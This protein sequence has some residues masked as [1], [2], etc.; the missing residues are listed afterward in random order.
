MSLTPLQIG[1]G[2]PD[3]TIDMGAVVC[4]ELT[5]KGSFRY[6]VR[7][8]FIPPMPYIHLLLARGLSLGNLPCC[9]GKGQLE[10]FGLS[11]VSIDVVVS[12][13][14]ESETLPRFSF[15]DARLAFEAT[16][17]GKGKDG[18]GVI[19]AIIS[20]PDVRVDDL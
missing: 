8:R 19:K 18:R 13:T 14:I 20:G 7:A 10:A 5:V 17:N 15:L 16:R 12:W 11:S 2:R 9:S 6:G 3:V 1:S 4:K